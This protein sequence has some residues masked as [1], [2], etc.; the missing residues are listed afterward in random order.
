MQGSAWVKYDAS[1]LR[2]SAPTMARAGRRRAPTRSAFVAGSV[3]DGFISF[4][5]MKINKKRCFFII[6][7]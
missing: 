3:A 5:F 4:H 6:E 7:G 1:R 2:R